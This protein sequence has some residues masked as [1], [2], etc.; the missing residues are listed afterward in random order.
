MKQLFYPRTWM[1]LICFCWFF[2]ATAF[3]NNTNDFQPQA[4]NR[5]IVSAP[6]NLHFSI[7]PNQIQTNYPECFNTAIHQQTLYLSIRSV[8]TKKFPQCSNVELQT[9]TIQA[10]FIQ[11]INQRQGGLITGHA[12]LAYDTQIESHQ[13]SIQLQLKNIENIHSFQV[14]GNGNLDLSGYIHLTHLDVSGTGQTQLHWINSPLL[15]IQAKNQSKVVLAGNVGTLSANAFHHAQIDVRFLKTQQAYVRTF[16]ASN[17]YL[18][19]I[20]S[21][22]AYAHSQSNIYYFNQPGSVAPITN[23]HGNVLAMNHI[24]RAILTFRPSE[25]NG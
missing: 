8:G 11:Q 7:G 1:L 10:P 22:F 16:Q 24:P 14:S 15:T 20:Q 19:V 3:E 18:F 6:L 4:F 23:A 13:G 17:A 9:L 25:F 21:L 5:I 12:I 2:N